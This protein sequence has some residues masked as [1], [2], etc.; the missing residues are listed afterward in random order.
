MVTPVQLGLAEFLHSC[1][2]HL[3]ELPAFYQRLRDRLAHNLRAGPLKFSPSAGTYFQMVDYAH[4]SDLPDT[5]VAHHLTRSLGVATIPISVFYP[6]DSRQ[7]GLRL[8]FAKH[9]QTLDEAAQRLNNIE[10]CLQTIA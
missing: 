9:D 2:Q 8:C 3:T 10:S 7:N 4:L 1:P 6:P 5:Q